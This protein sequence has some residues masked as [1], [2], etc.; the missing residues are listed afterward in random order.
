MMR[1]M[2]KLLICTLVL[3][4]PC[5]GFSEIYKYRDKDGQLNFVDDE[6]KI[7]A[8]YR[9]KKT[10]I[11]ETHDGLGSYDSLSNDD[12]IVNTA[13]QE[14]EIAET[15]EETVYE[16]KVVI[17]GNRVLVPVEAALG[18]RVAKLYLLLDTGATTTVFHRSALANLD[19]PSGRTYKARV[20]GGGTLTSKKIKF[21]HI[22][23]GPYK[24]EKT[25][26]MVINL[27][28]RKVPFDGMLGMDFLKNH[29][30]QIDF[31]R[32]LILWGSDD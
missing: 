10:S 19:L 16:S 11:S 31:E 15:S 9:D 25:D 20:A 8:E 6:N 5:I 17:K 27:K 1:L 21:R 29:P 4:T 28:G 12:E 13:E 26:A 2:Q 23:V 7:P 24:I 18:N 3:T 32:Q 30:Y 22:T 14:E